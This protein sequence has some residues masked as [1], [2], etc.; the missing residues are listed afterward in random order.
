MYILTTEYNQ[1]DQY[2]EYAIAVFPNKPTK[3]Q[4]EKAVG[5]DI[6]PETYQHILSGGGRIKYEDSWFYLTKFSPKTPFYYE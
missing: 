1:Y 5:D 3:E 6:T 2:G 4:V